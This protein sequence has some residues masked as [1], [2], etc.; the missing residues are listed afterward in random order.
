MNRTFT[1][2]SCITG[3]FWMDIVPVS[4]VSVSLRT[5]SCR[6]LDTAGHGFMLGQG[7]RLLQSPFRPKV[8]DEGRVGSHTEGQK[9]AG[10]FTLCTKTLTHCRGSAES[11][12]PA[13]WN[14]SGWFKAA[15]FTTQAFSNLQQNVSPV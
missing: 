15:T 8:G 5:V 7:G 11:L 3:M 2:W 13:D 14:Q 10:V 1:L 12:R 9:P 6:A 4:V